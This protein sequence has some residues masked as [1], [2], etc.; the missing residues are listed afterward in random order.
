MKQRMTGR[1]TLRCMFWTRRQP[2]FISGLLRQRVRRGQAPRCTG[3]VPLGTIRNYGRRPNGWGERAWKVALEFGLPWLL[4]E[5]DRGGSNI[6]ASPG[7]HSRLARGGW[8]GP[9]GRRPRGLGTCCRFLHGG[10]CISYESAESNIKTRRESGVVPRNSPRLL[11]SP[12]LISRSEC[13]GR[14]RTSWDDPGG[15]SFGNADRRRETW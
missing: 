12:R 1:A 14:W 8:G 2:S 9:G 5:G 6:I 3:Q 11:V 10:K 7:D 4:N 15:W 13:S